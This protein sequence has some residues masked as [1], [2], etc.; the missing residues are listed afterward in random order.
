MPTNRQIARSIERS[1]SKWDYKRAI[2]LSD[3]ETK[4]RVITNL[5]IIYIMYH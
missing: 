5:R 1:M 3:N 2:R 4:T